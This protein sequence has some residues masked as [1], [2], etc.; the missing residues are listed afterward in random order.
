MALSALVS[1]AKKADRRP[2]AVLNFPSQ[3]IHVSMS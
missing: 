3:S 1:S 2:R